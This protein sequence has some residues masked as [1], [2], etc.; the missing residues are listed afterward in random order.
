MRVV[1]LNGFF[2]LLFSLFL[3]HSSFPVARV[4]Y[5]TY[6]GEWTVEP[7]PLVLLSKGLTRERNTKTFYCVLLYYYYFIVVYYIIYNCFMHFTVTYSKICTFFYSCDCRPTS[8]SVYRSMAN[9]NAFVNSRRSVN[10]SKRY[11]ATSTILISAFLRRA[12]LESAA[13]YRKFS[14]ARSS[15]P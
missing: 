12:H 5:S 9:L 6:S 3:S 7:M 14:V 15:L 1:Q 13:H 2:V 4:C 8:K 11:A 10:F